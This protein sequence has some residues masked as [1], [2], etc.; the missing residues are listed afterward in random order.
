MSRKL[1]V[2]GNGLGMALDNTKFSLP[3][4]MPKV[5][6]EKLER[7]ERE[8]IA[9]FIPGI[10]VSTEPQEESRLINAQVALS[11]FDILQSG[12]GHDYAK[13]LK[14]WF[15]KPNQHTDLENALNKFTFE[16]AREF[17]RTSETFH[18]D[19]KLKNFWR[20]L[21]AHLGTHK[22]HIATFNYDTALYTKYLD[23]PFFEE[24]TVLQDCFRSGFLKPTLGKVEC[25]R[26][27]YL[28]LHGSPLFHD[29]IQKRNRSELNS[30]TAES[31]NHII[32]SDASLK[33]LLIAK[34]KIL[35]L[36]WKRLE[37]ILHPDV[38]DTTITQVEEIIL[39]GYR[40]GD[41]HL[42]RL[43]G[44]SGCPVRVVEWCD[45]HILPDREEWWKDKL[46]ATNVIVDLRK[47]ILTFNEW[48]S[49]PTESKMKDD[50]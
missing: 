2:V 39:F 26:G 27:L 40:G 11:A 12:F 34:S 18:D 8:L 46:G 42:N 31:R 43:I 33:P 17:D 7:N 41:D 15:S 1:I 48:D 50:A 38:R 47:N 5:W 16:V 24:K 23:D 4:A 9:D 3:H 22:S 44:K 49:R 37:E 6:H 29:T 14:E 10:D 36:Y 19:E 25:E 35:S 13:N 20:N 28:H 32:L 21:K 30:H 45:D